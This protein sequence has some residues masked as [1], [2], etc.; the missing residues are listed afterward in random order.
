MFVW[1]HA[2]LHIVIAHFLWMLSCVEGS[3]LIP[4]PGCILTVCVEPHPT[5]ARAVH[6]LPPSTLISLDDVIPGLVPTKLLEGAIS[7]HIIMITV[8]ASETGLNYSLFPISL[9]VYV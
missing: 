2:D 4:I 6:L 3:S 1:W 5:L 9:L 8:W 7:I